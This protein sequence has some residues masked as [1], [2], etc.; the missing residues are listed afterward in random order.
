MTG[1][2][3]EKGR[4]MRVA[5]SAVVLRHGERRFGDQLN[6]RDV[7]VF[8][9][10]G[11]YF[12]HYD[13]AGDRGW[14]ASLATS[15]D[16]VTWIKHGPVLDLGE[17]ADQD[18]GSASYGT[19]YFDGERWHMFYLGTPN[20]SA[21]EL[22]TPSFPYL[23]LKAE[24]AMPEG[25]WLKRPDVVPFVPAEGTWY[26]DT[27]SPGQVLG[28]DGA[29]IMVFSASA[30]D[31][32]GQILRTLGV[33]RTAD[34]D[35]P[36]TIDDEPLLPPTE[37][38]ENSSLYWDGADG[39]WYLF[40][41]HVA[42]A[43]DIAPVPPQNSSEYT[44][45]VWVYWSPDPTRFNTDDRAIVL[46]A[47]SSSWSPRVLGLPSVLEIDGRLAVYYDGCV[48]DTIGHGGRDI[49]LAWLNLPISSNLST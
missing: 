12:M 13:A 36:W 17:Q 37:Q 26:S 32:S 44:D 11:R 3:P 34:L 27:A 21:D 1:A 4:R 43:A 42:E 7:W 49:G 14:L 41:N 15:G 16:G 9:H 2:P 19:T 6:A 28:I 20:V 38:I 48:T 33:A 46:D 45:A 35:A 23:T 39:L 25:P 29:Y 5:D 8:E 10:S 30:T 47:E 18:S 40:T 24:A 31:P 22:K